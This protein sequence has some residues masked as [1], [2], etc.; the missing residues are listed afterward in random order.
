MKFPKRLN[1]DADIV[2]VKELISWDLEIPRYQRPYKWDTDN[3]NDLLNDIK[4]AIADYK[5]YNGYF[6][7]RIGTVIL[8]EEANSTKIVDGQ[9]RIISLLLLNLYLNSSFD[10]RLLRKQYSERITQINIKNNYAY[11]ESWFSVQETSLKKNFIDAMENVLEFVYIKVNDISTAFQFFDS[12]NNRGKSLYPHDLLKAYHLRKY[13]G[14]IEEKEAASTKWDDV[15]AYDM[16]NLFN[17][18]LYPILNW[19]RCKK[20]KKFTNKDI[21]TYKGVAADN[22]F[23]YGRK[24]LV[25]NENVSDK[26]FLITGPFRAGKDFFEMIDYYLTQLKF[27]HTEK[28]VEALLEANEWETSSIGFKHVRDL[29]YNTLFCYYNRFG[30]FDEFAIK[31]LLLWAFMLRTDL[32]NLGYDS[33]NKY[34]IGENSGKYSNGIP[35]FEKIIHASSPIELQK[36]KIKT[37]RNPDVSAK[38]TWNR[39]YKKLKE[40]NGGVR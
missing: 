15:N 29:F 37:V 22:P 11:I 27:I 16:I 20:A 19:S 2:S 13:I 4:N 12:Q 34:A 7:Y 5:K 30:D 40:I 38:D 14:N 3:I 33:I 10:C 1:M 9:Q 26:I 17:Q 18:N 31:N 32:E 36:L 28:N 24:I 25:E 39:L 23:S 35:M 6:K 8:H 21:S